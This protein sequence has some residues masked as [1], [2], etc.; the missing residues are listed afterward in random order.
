[1][2][3]SLSSVDDNLV[4]CLIKGECNYCKSS[5]KCI[6]VKDGLLTFKSADCNETYEKILMKIYLRSSKTHA[7]SRMQ[8]WSHIV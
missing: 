7:S 5:L 1:M 8:I 6:R 3:S 4:E 2:A